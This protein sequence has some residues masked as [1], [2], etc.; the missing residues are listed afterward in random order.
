MRLTLG[1]GP[2]GAWRVDLAEEVG[3]SVA[4]GMSFI[5]GHP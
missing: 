4:G 3:G 1:S 5:V 2:G